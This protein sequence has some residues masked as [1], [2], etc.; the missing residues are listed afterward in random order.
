MKLVDRGGYYVAENAVVVGRAA[1]GRGASI[2]YGAVVRADLE[3]IAIGAH[4]N[5][6]DG[7]VLHCDP[8]KP[9]A[10]GDF[11]TVGHMAMIHAGSV[12]DRCLIGIHSILLSG[13]VVGE[14]SIVAAGALIKEGQV[15]PPRSI[16][17]GIPG[18]VIGQVKDEQLKEADPRAQRYEELALRHVRGEFKG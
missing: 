9:L 6:Q 14:G 4:T 8:G 10:I 18:K 5:I 3:S 13:A 16:V 7:C 2:W 1:I 11:V 12:G 17:V 15:I